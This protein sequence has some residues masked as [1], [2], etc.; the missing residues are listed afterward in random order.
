MVASLTSPTSNLATSTRLRSRM[1]CAWG[2]H[3][4]SWPRWRSQRKKNY[5]QAFKST[6][7]SNF[8][9]STN[10]CAISMLQIWRSIPSVYTP[11]GTI[12]SCSLRTKFH[13]SSS[14]AKTSQKWVPS[15]S[16]NTNSNSPPGNNNNTMSRSV[17]IC[18]RHSQTC[19]PV[20]MIWLA[21]R[22]PKNSETKCQ[23]WRTSSKRKSDLTW[24][25]MVW[26]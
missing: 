16:R 8:G 15:N 10:C 20:P 21:R 2:R 13:S 19:S 14:P 3:M 22:Q 5:S 12:V 26:R 23:T 9:K 11:T 7:T 17:S 6:I 4:R 25:V 1:F 18:S 24:F